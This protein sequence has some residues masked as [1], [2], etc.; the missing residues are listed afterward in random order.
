MT[1]RDGTRDSGI[2]HCSAQEAWLLSIQLIPG[3]VACY[4]LTGNTTATEGGKEA[5]LRRFSSGALDGDMQNRQQVRKS[6]QH[7][8]HVVANMWHSCHSSVHFWATPTRW[9]SHRHYIQCRQ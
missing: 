4:S 2:S 8:R 6:L 9:H 7:Q 5:D 3:V 1:S